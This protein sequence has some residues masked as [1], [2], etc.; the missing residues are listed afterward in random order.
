LVFGGLTHNP[1]SFAGKTDNG[2]SGPPPF[3]ILN[4][5]RLS[6]LKNSYARIGGSQVDSDYFTHFQ[7]LL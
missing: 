1:L 3:G 6:A 4:N 5:R 7:L 2:G